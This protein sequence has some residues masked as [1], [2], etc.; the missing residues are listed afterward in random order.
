MATKSGRVVTSNE[1]LLSTKS[2]DLLIMWSSNFDFSHIIFRFRTQMPKSSLT[3]C[4][5]DVLN[6][7]YIFYI[8]YHNIFVKKRS[9]L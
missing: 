1:D 3:S 2:N 5:K 7:W 4:L 9:F 6:V 8:I